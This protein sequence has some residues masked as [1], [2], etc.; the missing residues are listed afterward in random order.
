MP[1]RP[2]KISTVL[3]LPPDTITASTVVYGGK[4]TGKTNFAAVLAEEVATAGL[5]FSLLDPMGVTWGLRHDLSGKGPGI[6]VLILGGIHGD[7]PI[8]PTGGQVV[9]DLVVD[10]NVS[11]IIDIS[12]RP[13][14]TMWAIAERVRFVRDYCKQIYRR[15]GEKRRPFLQ[16]IDEAARFAPQTIRA[17]DSDVA[18]CAGAVAVLVEEGRNVGIGVLLIT[19][20]SARLSKDVAEL[21][22]CMIAFRTVG[23]NSMLAVMSWL[24]EYVEKARHKE[25]AAK[26]RELPIGSALVV[27]PGWL[28]YE[29]VVAMRARKTFDSSATPK[30]GQHEVRASGPGAM[31]DLARY[32]ARMAETI[33]R[34]KEEDPRLLKLEISRL[35]NLAANRTPTVAPAPQRIEIPTPALSANDIT[36]LTRLA[37]TIDEAGL[38]LGQQVG[39]SLEIVARLRE[40]LKLAASRP[41]LREH[42][43]AGPKNSSPAIPR[44]DPIIEDHERRKAHAQRSAS[45]GAA[46]TAALP[47]AERKILT[48]L[49]QSPD[50]RTKTQLA[51]LAGYAA[52]SKGFNNALGRLRS[53]AFM[54]GPNEKLRITD[55]GRQARGDVPKLPS[56]P[57]LR[58]YWMGQVGKAER[59]V[60]GVLVEVYPATLSKDELAER[61]GYEAGGKGFNNALGQ[62]RTLELIEGRLEMR[63]SATLF[64]GA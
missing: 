43:D 25:L 7:I 44:R 37:T 12:R 28:K 46:E 40:V 3:A 1:I 33:E 35:R 30:P 9:A 41:L 45:R 5:R 51:L 53:L 13:D 49:A 34:A 63:A 48:V 29:G 64:E 50:G 15:N 59:L 11:V 36:L 32:Q 4:G 27:S 60:L 26:L 52:K 8:E 38:H 21:A 10:E 62:L 16:I 2:L 42:G 24:G 61:A 23:P 58:E 47:L 39:H 17:G 57:A 54:T 18:V 6:E 19:Q 14:G 20:R 55:A 56:G 22:D 31:P